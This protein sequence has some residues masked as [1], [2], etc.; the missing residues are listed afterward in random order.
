MFTLEQTQNSF[1]TGYI[2]ISLGIPRRKDHSQDSTQHSLCTVDNPLKTVSPVKA[3]KKVLRM[4]F[5]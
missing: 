3:T 4:P 1:V 5:L 2:Y